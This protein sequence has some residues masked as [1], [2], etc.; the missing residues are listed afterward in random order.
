MNTPWAKVVFNTCWLPASAA[1]NL[2]GASKK[3]PVLERNKNREGLLG[4]IANV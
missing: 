3:N 2:S 4:L 1:Q